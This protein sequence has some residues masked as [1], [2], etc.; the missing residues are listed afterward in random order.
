[1]KLLEMQPAFRVNVAAPP[2]EALRRLRQAIRSPELAGHAESA[3]PCLDFKV[4]RSE[5]RM[6]SPHLSVQL[7]PT[8]EGTELYCRFSPRPEIWTCVMMAY[9]AAV[10]VMFVAAIYGYVLYTLDVRPWPLL[11]VPLGAIVMF[12][13]HVVS[14]VGQRLSNDQ[15]EVLHDRLDRAVELAFAEKHT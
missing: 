13:L 12:S 7:Y 2:D 15:M 9:F 4:A 5:R 3:G 6:W 8:D 10:F 1:M 14:L 11:L